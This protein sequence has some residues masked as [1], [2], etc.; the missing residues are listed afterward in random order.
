[1]PFALNYFYITF[2][3]FFEFGD[4]FFEIITESASLFQ[5]RVKLSVSSVRLMYQ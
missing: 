1:M 2:F 5:I 3:F 4:N